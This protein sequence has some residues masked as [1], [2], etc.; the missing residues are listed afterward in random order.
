MN[1]SPEA[2][3][4]QIG[5]I[6]GINLFSAGGGGFI[7]IGID[8]LWSNESISWSASMF[9]IGFVIEWWQ[10]G[11]FLSFEIQASQNVCPQSGKIIGVRKGGNIAR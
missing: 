10:R 4:V 8:C 9:L 6:L 3:K 7:S 2:A 5:S 11:H 1:F